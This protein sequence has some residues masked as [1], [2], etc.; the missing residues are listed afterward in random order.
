MSKKNNNNRVEIKSRFKKNS[1]YFS[2]QLDYTLDKSHREQLTFII[3]I[4]KIFD[5]AEEQVNEYFISIIHII[6]STGV[7]L[8]EEMKAQFAVL[9]INLCDC[10]GKAYG[11]GANMVGRH[12]GVESR[13][14]SE[15]PRALFVPCSAH[16]LNLLLGDMASSVPMAMSFFWHNSVFLHNFGASTER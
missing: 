13:I 15:N 16:S 14:L 12:Q 6:S 5:K 9:E 2:V 8:T 1:K 7:S 3:R 4:V 10:C 11:K